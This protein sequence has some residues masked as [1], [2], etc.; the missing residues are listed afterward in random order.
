MGPPSSS[1]AKIA[2]DCR[3][4]ECCTVVRNRNKFLL[5]RWALHYANNSNNW[6]MKNNKNTKNTTSS[7]FNTTAMLYYQ[8][9]NAW[10][11]KVGLVQ[12]IHDY[13]EVYGNE[14]SFVSSYE[15]N[16]TTS[17]GNGDIKTSTMNGIWHVPNSNCKSNSNKRNHNHHHDHPMSW[18]RG[19]GQGLNH[20]ERGG[21]YHPHYRH[22]GRQGRQQH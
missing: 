12:A 6:E 14:A 8:K 7:T 21:Q 17:R 9:C 18:H 5:N 3:G 16:S 1:S 13:M 19:N 4:F 2:A 10:S 15:H 22:N 20:R 11:T